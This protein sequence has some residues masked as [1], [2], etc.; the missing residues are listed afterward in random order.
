MWILGARDD[1]S[2]GIRVLEAAKSGN[3][4]SLIRLIAE[5]VDINS[6]FANTT[7]LHAVLKNVFVFLALF[8]KKS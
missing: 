6:T 3:I 8:I 1:D 7:A 5:G 2:D 4:T